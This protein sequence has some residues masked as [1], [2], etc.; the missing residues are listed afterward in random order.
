MTEAEALEARASSKDVPPIIYALIGFYLIDGLI[1]MAFEKVLERSGLD[2]S[3]PRRRT[4]SR[5]ARRTVRTRRRPREA[6][7]GIRWSAPKMLLGEVPGNVRR[8]TLP[9]P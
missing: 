5:A 6:T 3:N 4:L 9:L 2:L 1:L 8:R 7:R